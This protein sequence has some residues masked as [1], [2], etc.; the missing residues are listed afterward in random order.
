[1]TDRTPLDD[2]TSD[3]LDQLYDRLDSMD[4]AVQ[5]TAAAALA[6]SGCH[7]KLMHQCQR[8]EHA[9]AA[10]ASVREFATRLEEFAENALKTGDRQL[11]AALAADLRTAVDTAPDPGTV[12]ITQ[13]RHDHLVAGQCIHHQEVHRLHHGEPVT[14]CPYPGCHPDA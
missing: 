13:T 2:L 8:A 1:M 7:S 11:Y 9:E 5:S 6:H 12:T 14:G 10:I 4:A 3:A